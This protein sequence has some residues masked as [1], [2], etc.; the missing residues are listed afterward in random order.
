VPVCRPL[1]LESVPFVRQPHVKAEAQ[2]TTTSSGRLPLRAYRSVRGE[3]ARRH[4][5]RFLVS[6]Q[7]GVPSLQDYRRGLAVMA[8]ERLGEVRRLAIANAER[9]LGHRNSAPAQQLDSVAHANVSSITL[10]FMSSTIR[11]WLVSRPVAG[12][13]SFPAWTPAGWL[14]HSHVRELRG[15][16]ACRSAVDIGR[17]ESQLENRATPAVASAYL[18]GSGA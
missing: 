5:D 7:V 12:M 14:A 16:R 2:P 17:A 10:I 6:S 3:S 9:D 11:S 4:A 15:E 18:T 1:A 13:H 8:P